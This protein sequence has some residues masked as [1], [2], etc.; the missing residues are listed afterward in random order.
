MSTLLQA[1][2][3][4]SKCI[5]GEGKKSRFIT[6]AFHFWRER[7]MIRRYEGY[8]QFSLEKVYDNYIVPIC[9]FEK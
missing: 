8:M 7:G 6:L 2:K 9:Y 4:G 5:K 1:P 3:A